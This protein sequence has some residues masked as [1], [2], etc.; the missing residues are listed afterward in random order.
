MGAAS[1][2]LTHVPSTHSIGVCRLL[3][4]C[5]GVCCDPPLINPSPASPSSVVTRLIP[6]L[7]WT[8]VWWGRVY[9]CSMLW[10]TGKCVDSCRVLTC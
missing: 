8:H 2:D 4:C 3:C 7:K 9:I 10:A 1:E 5:A 6:K